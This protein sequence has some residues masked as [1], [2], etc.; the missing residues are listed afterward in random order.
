MKK[1]GGTVKIKFGALD[2]FP[3]AK[4]PACNFF[5]NNDQQAFCLAYYRFMLFNISWATAQTGWDTVQCPVQ[6]KQKVQNIT[7]FAAMFELRTV[8]VFELE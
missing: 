1:F 8:G 7:P 5:Q 4:V 2:I 6:T 3:N